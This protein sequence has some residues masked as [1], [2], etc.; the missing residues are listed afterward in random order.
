MKYELIPRQWIVKWQLD[1]KC[2]AGC[3]TR[4]EMAQLL[5]EDWDEYMFN[6]LPLEVKRDIERE[7]AE[8]WDPVVSKLYKMGLIEQAQS[9]MNESRE[10]MMQLMKEWYLQNEE[11]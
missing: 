10:Q 3:R 5:L 6:R 2:R 8:T 11:D 4:S 7:I 9:H 1:N